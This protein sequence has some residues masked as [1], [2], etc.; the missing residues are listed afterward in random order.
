M[1]RRID[2]MS[3]SEARDWAAKGWMDLFRT[4]NGEWGPY[5]AEHYLT[6]VL[7]ADA[8]DWLREE[9]ASQLARVDLDHWD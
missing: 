8:P 1:G 6:V 5:D 3:F 4:V 9:L 2:D 7:P